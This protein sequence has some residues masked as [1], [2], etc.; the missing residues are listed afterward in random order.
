MIQMGYRPPL[1][2]QRPMPQLRATEFLPAIAIGLESLPDAR[3][4]P[5]ASHI[6]SPGAFPWRRGLALLATLPL[7]L[8]M[9]CAVQAGRLLHGRL[10]GTQILMMADI[11][12]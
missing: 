4:T 6:G 8:V 12:E 9:E 11:A 10:R 1:Q 3:C 5:V 7:T 2:H